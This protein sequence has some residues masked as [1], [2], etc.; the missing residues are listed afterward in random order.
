MSSNIY[1][2]LPAFVDYT[3]LLL[4]FFL[5]GALSLI[6]PRV[7]DPTAKA[8]YD[9]KYRTRR[10]RESHQLSLEQI[11]INNASSRELHRERQKK[12]ALWQTMRQEALPT[13]G[14]KGP[15]SV[16]DQPLPAWG[17]KGTRSKPESNQ[18]LPAWGMKGFRSEPQSSLSLSRENQPMLSSKANLL[19]S[20]P[21]QPTPPSLHSSGSTSPLLSSFP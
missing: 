14:A 3:M 8:G 13:W 2:A 4:F 17:A 1:D 7:F 9:K 21:Q 6:L 5:C 12:N 11:D 19:A 10:K 18:P 15:R 20:S 16:P